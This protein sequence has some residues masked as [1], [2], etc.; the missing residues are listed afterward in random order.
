MPASPNR[1]K[2]GTARPPPLSACSGRTRRA[3]GAAGRGAH[4]NISGA[5]IAKHA[6]N[7]ANAV[8]LIDF[9]ASR[10]AQEIY[11][12]IVNEYPVRKD[13]QPGRIVPDFGEFKAD[14]LP[15]AKLADY[16][17]EAIRLADRAGWR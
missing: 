1:R 2:R 7:R 5:G 13:V 6:R 12:R 11:A 15:L 14:S 10:E 17:K 4:V 8:K 3:P 9:L 16:Q